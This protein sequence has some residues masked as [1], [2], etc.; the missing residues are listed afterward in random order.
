MFCYD[1]AFVQRMPAQ[2][3][4]TSSIFVTHGHGG[5]LVDQATHLIFLLNVSLN[6]DTFR[7]EFSS[8]GLDHNGVSKPFAAVSFACGIRIISLFYQL[9]SCWNKLHITLMPGQL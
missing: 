4:S 7:Q 3:I 6:T 9:T 8:R 2:G 5:S 1:I